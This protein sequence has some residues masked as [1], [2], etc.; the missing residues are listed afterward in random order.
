M[1]EGAGL[2]YS[3]TGQSLAEGCLER[4]ST[5]R[6]FQLCGHVGKATPEVKGH[7][8]NRSQVQDMGS[9]SMQKQARG[10]GAQEEA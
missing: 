10:G 2:P 7:F 3:H 4:T 8:R 9:K 1:I 5:P 6:H